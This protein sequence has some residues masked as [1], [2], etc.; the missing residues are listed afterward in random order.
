[1]IN[2]TLS[3]LS[4]A[5][6]LQEEEKAYI[7]HLLRLRRDSVLSGNPMLVRDIDILIS[8]ARSRIALIAYEALMDKPLY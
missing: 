7:Q 1:M 4:R 5:L 8:E 3:R 6:S 2:E